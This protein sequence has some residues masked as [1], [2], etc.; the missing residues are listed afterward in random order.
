MIKLLLNYYKDTHLINIPFSLLLG[1]ISAF[2]GENF[3]S[4]FVFTFSLSLLTGGLFLSVYF[5]HLRYKEQYYFYYNRGL[6]NLHL[7]LACFLINVVIVM[8]AK[9]LIPY[10]A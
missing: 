3:W 4:T 7:I 9:S 5:Y 1:F 2:T 8:F 6:T 10:S